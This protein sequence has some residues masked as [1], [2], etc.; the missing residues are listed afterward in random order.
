MLAQRKAGAAATTHRHRLP[1]TAMTVTVLLR[2]AVFAALTS[3]MPAAGVTPA[4]RAQSGLETVPLVE[5]YT[6]EG[7]DSCPPADRWLSGT[8]ASGRAPTPAVALAFHVDYRDRLG[9]KDRFAAAA[10]TKRQ[11]DSARARRSDLVYTPQVLLQGREVDWRNGPYVASA[12]AAAARAPARAAI[13]LAVVPQS[14]AV[15]VSVVARVP[16]AADRRGARAFVAL[17]DDGLVS[18]VRAGENAGKRLAHD[19]VVRALRDVAIDTAGEGVGTVVLPWPA[20]TGSASTVTAFVEDVETG[21][22]LQSLSLPLAA[23]CLP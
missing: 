3:A 8:F 12:L 4:C 9:W 16:D 13:S 17:S 21:A 18:D 5:L 14:G 22:V 11:Y 19:H 7:C 10:W 15:A 23:G 6:S 20:E 2:L 1:E